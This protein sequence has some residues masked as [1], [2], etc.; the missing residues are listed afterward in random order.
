MERLSMVL[1]ISIEDISYIM[2]CL[3]GVVTVGVFMGNVFTMI[4]D[5]SLELIASLID[6]L[7]RQAKK[8]AK[9]ALGNGSNSQ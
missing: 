6:F 4:L 2:G 5:T 3:M 9:K 8:A 7:Y 1:G